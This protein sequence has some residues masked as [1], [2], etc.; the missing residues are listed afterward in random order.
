M[1]PIPTFKHPRRNTGTQM[2][3]TGE[4]GVRQKQM[5]SA[6][7]TR[8]AGPHGWTLQ[9][10]QHHGR[11]ITSMLQRKWWAD[12]LNCLSGLHD[13]IPSGKDTGRLACSS[14]L[15]R[16]RSMGHN[17]CQ[18]H[19]DSRRNSYQAR[20]WRGTKDNRMNHGRNKQAS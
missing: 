8:P 13:T 19:K 17:P 9:P 3:E 16:G 4:T 5:P 1:R 11:S 6:S 12:I 14:D 20:F 10:M 2:L 7:E 18:R 15:C